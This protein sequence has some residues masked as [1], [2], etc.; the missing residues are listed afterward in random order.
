VSRHA[1]SCAL[2]T[3]G[4]PAVTAT[5]ATTTAAAAI[6]HAAKK[7]TDAAVPVAVTVHCR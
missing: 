1:G 6:A 2:A 4:Y 7:V 3:A 5:A